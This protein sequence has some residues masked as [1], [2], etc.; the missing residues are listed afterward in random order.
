[1][2]GSLI[3]AGIG[4]LAGG[5]TH[6]NKTVPTF[7]NPNFVNSVGVNGVGTATA[8]SFK[9]DRSTGFNNAVGTAENNLNPLLNGI[10]NHGSNANTEKF[11][12]AYIN[13]RRPQLDQSIANRKNQLNSNIARQGLGGSSAA[14]LAQNMNARSNNEQIQQLLNQGVLGGQALQQQD[15]QNQINKFGL[16]NNLS[17][18]NFGNTLQSALGL[19]G[20]LNQNNQSA[21]NQANALNGIASA[22]AQAADMN[23]GG[24]MSS[25]LSGAIGGASLGSG[26]GGMGGAGGSG[27]GG[28]SSWLGGL[29]G[30]GGNGGASASGYTGDA[31]RN[32]L[33]A[34]NG[35]A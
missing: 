17:Q 8:N 30:G 5:L 25:I 20:L 3:G 4:A 13:A 31:M 2:L 27:S 29:F 6:N 1:M 16:A 33:A 12:N 35:R 23:K 24:L 21:I 10:L 7:R 14:L 18:Q 11:Q 22:R 26:L 15:L 34:G 28:I 32:W 9:S 19:D